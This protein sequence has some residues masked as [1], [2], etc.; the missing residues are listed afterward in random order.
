MLAN[1]SKFRTSFAAAS[2]FFLSTA[3]ITHAAPNAPA[4]PAKVIPAPLTVAEG[5]NKAALQSSQ[6]PLKTLVPKIDQKKPPRYIIELNATQNVRQLGKEPVIKVEEPLERIN[7]DG[8][9]LSTG[10]DDTGVHIERPPFDALIK[11]KDLLNPYSLDARYVTRVGLSDILQATL[12]QNLEIDNAYSRMRSQKYAFLSS[13]SGFLPSLNAGYTLIGVAGTFP[14]DLFGGGS[15]GAASAQANGSTSQSSFPS[16]IQLAN[17]GFNQ[18]LYQGGKILFQTKSD[19]HRL[20]AR[21][22]DLKTNV[23]DTLLNAARRYYELLLNE[24]LLAIRTRAVAISEEQVRLNS[25]Q[26]KAGVATGLDV[27]QSQAQLAS[28]QQNLIDQQ[29]TRRQSA[30]QLAHIMNSSFAEDLEPTEKYLRKKRLVTKATPIEELLKLAIDNRPE[31]KQYE[32]LRLA[33]KNQIVVAASAL[34]PKVNLAG[35]VYGI[36]AGGGGLDPLYSLN[37]GIKWALGGLG[38]TDL[39]NT[40]RARWDAR[41]AAIQAKQTFL[42]IFDEV[43]TSHNN[44]LAAEKRIDLASIQIQAAEEELRIARKRMDSGVGLNIDVL[45]AQRDLTQASI[46]KARAILDFNVAQAQLIRDVGLINADR[47]VSGISK[48]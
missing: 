47:L 2:A 17:V 24:A 25:A 18:N 3:A 31:L 40:Q 35:T 39:A 9:D 38:T 13:A 7:S 22:A 23:N 6:K 44:S 21:R 10:A 12:N 27:L 37:F 14:S 8:I 32:E 43:R 41:T 28:D 45:N 26:E 48:Y 4:A 16:T 30:I 19:A 34:Q 42:N 29:N 5:E 1:I 33:A 15:S 20:R 11:F 46:N 36:G